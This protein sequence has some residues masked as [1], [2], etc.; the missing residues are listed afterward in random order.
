MAAGQK[1]ATSC[2]DDLKKVVVQQQKFAGNEDDYT[3]YLSPRIS[4]SEVEKPVEN[5]IENFRNSICFEGAI[6]FGIEHNQ[7]RN[8][9]SANDTNRAR[10]KNFRNKP[11]QPVSNGLLK[12]NEGAKTC[13]SYLKLVK[14]RK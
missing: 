13:G 11:D 9:Y 8:V 1:I 10:H 4:Q 5:K 3:P 12:H 6:A 7:S 2:S 14:I